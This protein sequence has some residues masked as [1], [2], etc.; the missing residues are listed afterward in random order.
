[1][2][3]NTWFIKVYHEKHSSTEAAIPLGCRGTLLPGSGT[4][5]TEEMNSCTSI[6]YS[7]SR[8]LSPE[9]GI[10]ASAQSRVS[11]LRDPLL[12]FVPLPF[13]RVF[14][15]YGFPVQIKSNDPAILEAA[16]QNWGRLSQR[17]D[18]SQIE[19]RYLVTQAYGKRCPAPP[20]YRACC[21]LNEGFGSAWL[22]NTAVRVTSYL[23]YTFLEGMIST[24]LENRHFV[25]LHAASVAK[26]SHGVLLVADSGVGK[27]SLS[28]ACASRGWTYISDDASSLL[29]RGTGRTVIGNP[30]VL[31]FRPT[32]ADL[33]PELRAQTILGPGQRI[34]RRPR[35]G[36]PTV[37]IRTEFLPHIRIAEECTVDYIVFLKRDSTLHGSSH[38]VPMPREGVLQRLLPDVFPAELPIHQQR[39]AAVERLLEAQVCEMSYSDLDT[40]V[41]LLE[42]LVKRGLS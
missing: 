22:T 19:A 34:T 32:A 42:D 27:S 21:D 14:Y 28:Y 20:D 35:N 33:F 37:E 23:R 9:H 29:Y 12:A 17:F 13:Q 8:S 41:D 40:A 1:M 18:E 38:V 4:R 2:F 36:K 24:L 7:M 26:N 3:W 6:S 16:D 31:R 25:S 15:P 30:R 5:G 39:V 11:P 10:P